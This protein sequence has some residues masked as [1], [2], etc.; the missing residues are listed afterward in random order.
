MSMEDIF[1]AL[2]DSRQQGGSK[3]AQEDPMMGLIGGLLGGTQ[4][5]GG[6]QQA[7]LGDLLGG[8][9]GSA[10]QGGGQQ[11]AGLGDM[12]GLLESVIGGQGSAQTSM[13]ANNPIMGLLQP[14]VVPLAKKAKI[15]PEIAMIVVS[16]VARKLLAHHPTSG[17][18]SREFDFDDMLQQM[19]S[20]RINQDLLRSSG[21]VNEL[22]KATGLDE[23]T[24]TKTL[25]TAFV[26]VGEQ[27]Q[28]GSPKKPIRTKTTSAVA[29]TLKSKNSSSKAK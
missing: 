7:G 28:S 15:P 6:Q 5:G 17:R 2:V 14:F 9:M 26:M 1:K 29:K 16:F 10:Q 20:G 12:M 24:T 21:M 3:S 11:Q 8:L 22:S 27:F 18:D 23:A 4:Q 13:G 19:N 25:N